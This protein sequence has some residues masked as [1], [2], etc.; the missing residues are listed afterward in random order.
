MD[1]EL[2][3]SDVDRQQ[4]IDALGRHTAEGRLTL[5]EFAARVD[6][7]ARSTTV[8][9]LAAV[10]AD[11]PTARASTHPVHRGVVV[12]AVVLAVVLVALL[13]L[14]LL[15]AFTGGPHMGGMMG[16]MG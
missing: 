7:A 14:A 1:A 11:L 9:E 5:D 12:A 16:S 15:G 6:T 10:T 3:A 8:A 13:G 4:V 2:R